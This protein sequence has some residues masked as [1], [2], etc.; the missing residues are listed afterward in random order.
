MWEIFYFTRE[1]GAALPRRGR[2][3]L[4]LGPVVKVIS[5]VDH[6]ILMRWRELSDAEWELMQ[7]LM[8]QRIFGRSWLDDRTVLNGV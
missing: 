1:T 8:P 5:V 6:G 4:A 7:P 3:P 2:S